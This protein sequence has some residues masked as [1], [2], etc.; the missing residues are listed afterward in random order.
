[1]DPWP[2]LQSFERYAKYF[3]I[4]FAF[5]LTYFTK[6]DDRGTDPQKSSGEILMGREGSAEGTARIGTLI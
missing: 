4:R 2:S 6:S 3:S 1:M 5:F